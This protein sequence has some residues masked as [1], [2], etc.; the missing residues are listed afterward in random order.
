[1]SDE[2]PGAGTGTVVVSPGDPLHTL[3]APVIRMVAVA[4]NMS[5]AGKPT[6]VTAMLNIIMQTHERSNDED[7]R[8]IE[9]CLQECVDIL[10]AE[11]K[12]RS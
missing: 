8:H 11:R 10:A 12:K 4:L 9:K 3:L 7:Q 5:G 2:L 6:G 1:M